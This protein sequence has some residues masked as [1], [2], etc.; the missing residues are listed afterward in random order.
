MGQLAISWL[1]GISLTLFIESAAMKTTANWSSSRSS[2]HFLVPVCFV[3][4][5]PLPVVHICVSMCLCV[6]QSDSSFIAPIYSIPAS[7]PPIVVFVFHQ[8]HF[9]CLGTASTTFCSLYL[10][11]ARLKFNFSV[12]AIVIVVPALWLVT[13]GVSAFRRC[14]CIGHCCDDL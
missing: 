3:S 14:C 11:S 8:L 9:R 6:S 5:F 13:N 4:P 7:A 12:A 10:F 2:W 1:S